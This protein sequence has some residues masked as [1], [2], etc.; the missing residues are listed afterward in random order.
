MKG[1]LLL[2]AVCVSLNAACETLWKE[3]GKKLIHLGWDSPDVDYL[4]KNIRAMED[5]SPF[6]GVRVK[7]DTVVR[8]GADRREEILNEYTF[9]GK[10][11]W[12][13]EWLKATEKKLKEIEFRQFTDNLLAA[14]FRER[15]PWF[16]D[17]EWEN[18]VNNYAMLA[19]L[20]RNT[21]FKGLSID[22]EQYWKGKEQFQY[23]AEEDGP[24]YEKACAKARERGRAFMNAIARE[25]PG[26]TLFFTYFHSINFPA[27]KA[28]D[29][30]RML[31]TAPYDKYNLFVPFSNGML[32]VIPPEAKI[33][34]GCENL[35]YVAE[36]QIDFY[37][38]HHI[39]KSLQERL[40][41][42]ENFKKSRAQVSFAP[43]I[44][45]DVYL[46]DRKDDWALRHRPENRLQYLERN[47]AW[48]MKVADEYVWVFT[49]KGKWWDIPYKPWQEKTGKVQLWE[50]LFPGI[51][52]VML[53]AKDATRWFAENP[54]DNFP[55]RI[56][57]PSF[58]G[59]RQAAEKT[60]PHIAGAAASKLPGWSIIPKDAVF[61]R[62]DAGGTG[63]NSGV[64]LAKNGGLILQTVPVEPGSRYYV[65]VEI[66][67]DDRKDNAKLTV[68]WIAKATGKWDSW[69]N[70]ARSFFPRGKG[71]DGWS[72]YGEVLDVPDGVT[73][74]GII[75]STG[76]KSG[77]A[78]LPECRFRNVKLLKIF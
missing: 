19:R 10:K 51:R 20:A 78:P 18:L 74:I 66:K 26:I 52:E 41:Y 12:R 2:A 43:S 33:L 48:T 72:R 50:T 62:E 28:S 37:R 53:R 23:K 58:R 73:H 35:G 3:P 49:C 32:D 57:N 76:M 55:N 9:T 70:H 6:D 75:L 7:I 14:S 17:S 13:Y 31:K 21:G 40:V 39:Q 4:H 16:N 5:G 27:A 24:S 77:T 36:N 34:D 54:H 59:G 60:G 71:E 47:L 64:L 42:P 29:T 69:R 30:E 56:K 61:L 45:Q 63:G 1:F 11:R 8:A 38:M 15:S 25:Y 68:Q 67:N 46:L 44:W 65:G 22:V